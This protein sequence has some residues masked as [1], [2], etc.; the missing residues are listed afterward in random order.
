MTKGTKKVLFRLNTYDKSLNEEIDED[1]SS[2]W[3][4]ACNA[5]VATSMAVYDV[6]SGKSFELRTLI[7]NSDATTAVQTVQFYDA[8]PTTTPV[9]KVTLGT[10]ETLFID[11]KNIYFTDYVYAVAG[12][13]ST[14]QITVGGFLRDQRP[15]GT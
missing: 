15:D 8:T 2:V 6:P 7:I 14:V 12:L 3:A 11:L 1:R 5:A 13:A 9:F 10:N 4:A